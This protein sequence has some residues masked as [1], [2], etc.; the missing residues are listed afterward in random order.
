[1]KLARAHGRRDG[2]SRDSAFFHLFL[3][4]FAFGFHYRGPTSVM[5]RNAF[6]AATRPLASQAVRC[7]FSS[8]VHRLI[9]SYRKLIR[10][11]PLQ[12]LQLW[13]ESLRGCVLYTFLSVASTQ[14]CPS[15]RPSM[16]VY[17]LYV[18]QLIAQ[19]DL[20]RSRPSRL[21]SFQ[22]MVS[23]Q[24]LRIPSRKS[25]STSTPP[26]NGNSTMSL[27]CRRRARHCLSRPW[28]V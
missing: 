28:R 7:S 14:H 23:V 15:R 21:P 26:L 22:V 27:A 10:D 12:L 13:P 25:S 5:L 6:S 18:H 16:A 8:G 4:T 17:T 1:M 11:P 19:N 3:V 9:T 20:F 24:K 2:L